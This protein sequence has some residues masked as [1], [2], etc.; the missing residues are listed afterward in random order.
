MNTNKTIAE[1]IASEYITKEESKLVA[2]KKLDRK[3]KRPA[4]IFA[5]SFG[6]IMTLVLGTGMTLAMRVIGE[7]EQAF[8][9]GIVIGIIG[10]IGVGINYPI[11]NKLLKNSKMKYASDII[12]LAKEITKE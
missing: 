8:I 1:R 7:G 9:F 11:Y 5:Y 12:A 10:I 3:A 6:I 2:L 4:E